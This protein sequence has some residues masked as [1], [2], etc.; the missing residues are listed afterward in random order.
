MIIS[1]PA[2]KNNEVIAYVVL[3]IAAAI[4]AFRIATQDK[5]VQSDPTVPTTITPQ[6]VH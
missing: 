1:I 6:E 2:G 5:P 3:A 4:L